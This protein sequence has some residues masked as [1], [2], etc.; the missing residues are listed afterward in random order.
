MR[1]PSRRSR[2]RRQRPQRPAGVAR[3]RASPRERRG[4]ATAPPDGE[5]VGCSRAL[6]ACARERRWEEAVALLR[7]LPLRTLYADTVVYNVAISACGKSQRWVCALELLDEIHT[8]G[9]QPTAA[10]YN[11][12]ADGAVSAVSAGLGAAAGSAWS[13]AFALALGSR[14]V[15]LEP[16][17]LSYT[18]LHGACGSGG[19][20]WSLA[21]LALTAMSRGAL[22]PNVV[23][24]AA[25]ASVCGLAIQ[26][27]RAAALLVRGR[28]FAVEPNDVAHNVAVSACERGQQWTIALSLLLSTAGLLPHIIACNAAASACDKARRW[29]WSAQLVGKATASGLRPDVVSVSTALSAADKSSQWVRAALLLRGSARGP[30]ARGV[31]PGV[32][33]ANAAASACARAVAWAQAIGLLTYAGVTRLRADAVG[34]AAGA[35]ASGRSTAWRGAAQL[36]AGGVAAAVALDVAAHNAA[37]GAVGNSG[38]WNIA[39]QLIRAML[40]AAQAPS[41]VTCNVAIHFCAGALQ[42]RQAMSS[43][44]TMSHSRLPPDVASFSA[45]IGGA[46]ASDTAVGLQPQAAALLSEMTA[47]GVK[48]NV[49]TFGAAAEACGNC[50]R[51]ESLPRSLEV[52]RGS[53]LAAV[54]SEESALLPA[55][56]H[57]APGDDGYSFGFSAIVVAMDIMHWHG[58]ITAVIDSVFIRCAGAPAV[59]TLQALASPADSMTSPAFGGLAQLPGLG[60]H[61]PRAIQLLTFQQRSPTDAA[62]L[63]ARRDLLAA[64]LGPSSVPAAKVVAAWQAHSLASRCAPSASELRP[65]RGRTAGYGGLA[66]GLPL[67]L[68]PVPAEHDRSGHA[69][70]RGLLA[71][72]RLAAHPSFHASR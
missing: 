60:A 5:L 16:S 34:L 39:A 19:A 56:L 27:A 40:I 66:R 47:R 6:A 2:G 3:P 50:G 9:L 61:S 4:G 28:R 12:A 36:L 43:L 55:G 20:R 33:A 13:L 30:S 25:A 59:T 35:G 31:L 51:V 32:I 8:Q 22:L 48:P 63:G 52:L 62:R 57:R 58:D 10:S 53:A 54:R 64:C 14:S 37:I 18:A 17:V 24:C 1:P 70:L 38:Q 46:S 23:T 44:V 11:A 68:A 21:L 71:L 67:P 49:V 45:A 26:W 72:L 15:L 41:V 7:G 42:W 29:E 69:E 65:S